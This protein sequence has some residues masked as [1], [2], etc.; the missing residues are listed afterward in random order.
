MET[1]FNLVHEQEWTGNTITDICKEYGVSRKTYYKWKNRYN[2]NGISGLSDLSKVPHTLNYKAD[3]TI[4]ET[5]LDLRLKRFGCNRIRFRLKRL[6]V[7]LSSRTIYKI[8]KRHSLNILKCKIRNR[9][10]RRF[11]MKHPNDM[12][13][14]MDILGP[15][16]IHHQSSARNYIIISCIDDCS[17]KVASTWSERK[18]RSIDVLDLLEEWIMVGKR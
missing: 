17:R 3:T 18:S 9:K 13:V 8:L 12:M 1:K 16:Y 5:I 10:Y 7:Y 11:A 6:G 4:E 15:F 2:S 14:Q